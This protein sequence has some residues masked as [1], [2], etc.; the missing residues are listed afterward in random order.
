MRK[1]AYSGLW[2]AAGKLPV[3]V[4][5]FIRF[6]VPHV[7]PRSVRQVDDRLPSSRWFL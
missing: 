7:T 1:K 3:P 4:G 5:A 6:T 2:R